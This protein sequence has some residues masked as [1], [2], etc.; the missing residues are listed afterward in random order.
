M[1]DQK[2]RQLMGN[3][4]MYKD[5]FQAIKEFYANTPASILVIAEDKFGLL[6]YEGGCNRG[7]VKYLELEKKKE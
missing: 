6:F 7:V 3:V 2:K 4:H 1:A 5:R